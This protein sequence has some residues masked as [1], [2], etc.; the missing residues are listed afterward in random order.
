MQSMSQVGPHS[1]LVFS[2]PPSQVT[3]SLWISSPVKWDDKIITI[4]KY[5]C[6]D[7]PLKIHLN[8][9]S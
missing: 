3:K 9:H 6:K 7:K 5:C 8:E 4:A 1:N 2:L